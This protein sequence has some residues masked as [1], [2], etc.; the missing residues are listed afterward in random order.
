MKNVETNRSFSVLIPDGECTYATSVVRCL[1]EQKNIKTIALATDK[2]AAVRFSRYTSKFIYNVYGESNEERLTGII[3]AIKKT[4]ADILLPVDVGT[5]RLI[6]ENKEKLSKLIAIA[7]IPEV[8][9]FDIA[10]DKWLLSLWLKENNIAHPNTILFKSTNSLDETVSSITFPT[11]IKPRKGSG[12]KGIYIFENK[13]EF[14]S[15]YTEFDH[16]EDQIIQSYIKGYDIDCSVICSEGRILAHTIQKGL[17]YTVAYQWPYGVEFLDN[18]EIFNLVKEVV[19]KFKWSGV[20]HIDLRYDEVERKAKLIEM[21]PR[22]WASLAASLFAG[23]NFPYLSCLSGLK[24]E[25][26][27]LKTQEKRVLRTGPALKMT[28]N[29]LFKKQDYLPFDNTFGEFIMKDPLPN[30]FSKSLEMCNKYKKR[31]FKK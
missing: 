19:E 3:D 21:N 24:R 14:K 13:E 20:V 29:R 31:L 12:G 15:W 2:N 1:A 26:P 11:I 23:V 6:A 27:V 28:F 7:P 30:L 18:D 5:I 9:S 4:N 22:F 10:D 8:N 25:L 16:S 17:K